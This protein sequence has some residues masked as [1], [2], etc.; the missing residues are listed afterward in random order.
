MNCSPNFTVLQS[1]LRH[2]SRR[3]AA[4]LAVE[5]LLISPSSPFLLREPTP[6]P[7]EVIFSFLMLWC[8]T[9]LRLQ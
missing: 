6:A 4:D 7:S 1:Q 9:V 8:L 5:Q 3:Q 2:H